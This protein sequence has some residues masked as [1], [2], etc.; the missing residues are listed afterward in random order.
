MNKPAQTCALIA[1]WLRAGTNGRVD[2]TP[3]DLQTFHPDHIAFLDECR[4][5]KRDAALTVDSWPW[6]AGRVRELMAGRPVV[7]GG[8]DPIYAGA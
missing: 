3:A 1:A 8:Y 4:L 2:L 7:A 6:L 5:E